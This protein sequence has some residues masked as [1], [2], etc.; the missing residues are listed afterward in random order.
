MGDK[1]T[2]RE[3]HL[4]LWVFKKKRLQHDE[5]KYDALDES[6]VKGMFER[7]FFGTYK[8]LAMMEEHSRYA[9]L[10]NYRY[11]PKQLI[12]SSRSCQRAFPG[13]TTMQSPP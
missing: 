7:L 6:A 1:L 12:N 8:C 10:Y 9:W 5:G 3:R 13:T 2:L 11:T 4:L